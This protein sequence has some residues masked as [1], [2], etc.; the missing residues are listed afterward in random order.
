MSA[1]RASSRRALLLFQILFASFWV[2][3]LAAV[4]VQGRLLHKPYPY[5]TL[6]FIPSVRFTDFTIFDPRFAIWDHTTK[7]FDLPGFSFTYPA[8]LLVGF[9]AYWKLTPHPLA[10]YLITIVVFAIGAAGWLAVRCPALRFTL[11]LSL[12][13]A[14]PLFFLLD[15]ANIEGLVWITTVVA[16]FVFVR[17]HFTASAI[18]FGIA[19]GM[20]IFPGALLLLFL[21]NR[22]YRELTIGV[23][24]AFLCNL[25]ALAI[26]GPDIPGALRGVLAG[27]DF[28]RHFEILC[29]RP[30]QIGFEHSLF[31]CIKQVLHLALH[32]SA[33]TDA[34]LPTACLIYGAVVAVAFAAL[35]WLRIRRLPLLNQ[36]TALSACSVVLPFTSYDYTLVHLYAPFVAFLILLTTDVAAGR[37]RLTVR[38]AVAFLIPYT[39]IFAPLSWM[40][41]HS[42]GMGGQVKALALVALLRAAVTI[43]LPSSLFGEVAISKPARSGGLITLSLHLPRVR[44]AHRLS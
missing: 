31:S 6:L 38:E 1:A 24:S 2:V 15:R 28:F 18:L 36:F 3:A 17:R 42:S 43:P 35:Y 44:P 29:V 14:Y 8:P 30:D 23:V 11:A 16:S 27:M 5:D 4:F 32:S 12:A 37:T 7:F 25:A 20:K 34:L 10:Y 26:A 41:A 9:L 33:R 40:L 19:A 39:L 22:R 21:V 13:G